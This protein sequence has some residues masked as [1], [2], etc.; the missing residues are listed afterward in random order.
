MLF[1]FFTFAHVLFLNIIYYE[2]IINIRIRC[3]KFLF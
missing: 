1:I 2:E 3:A